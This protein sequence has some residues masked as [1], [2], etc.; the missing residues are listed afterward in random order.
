V[1]RIQ[2]L[3]RDVTGE[4]AKAGRG[5][6]TP[7]ALYEDRW[8]ENAGGRTVAAV[9]DYGADFRFYY[10]FRGAE[11]PYADRLTFV[12]ARVRRAGRVRVAEYLYGASGLLAF[13]YVKAPDG[14]ETRR[15]F[16][17]RARRGRVD[18]FG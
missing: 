13:A 2:A 3:Y 8:Q 9:G 16:D 15:Y 5:P 12:T 7:A 18:G 17:E 10:G 4:V 14:T 1:R 11:E 6:E